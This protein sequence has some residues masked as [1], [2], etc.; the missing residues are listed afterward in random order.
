MASLRATFP[1]TRMWVLTFMQPSESSQLVA[2]VSP[3][4]GPL[5]SPTCFA[6]ITAEGSL[7]WGGQ[8]V[9]PAGLYLEVQEEA[10]ASQA[11]GFLDPGCHL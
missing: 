9:Q 2:L 3:D 7:H 5:P 10:E 11:M 4:A 6:V 8:M 1:C